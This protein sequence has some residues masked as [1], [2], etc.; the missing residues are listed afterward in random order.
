MKPGEVSW[1]DESGVGRELTIIM[2]KKK[3]M[4]VKAKVAMARG[5]RRLL[6]P[7]CLWWPPDD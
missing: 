4:E 1:A 7:W 5:V 2:V 6:S 3:M